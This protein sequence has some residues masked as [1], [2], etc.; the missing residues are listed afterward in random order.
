MWRRGPQR[1]AVSECD[2]RAILTVLA[3]LGRRGS[4]TLESVG[5]GALYNAVVADREPHKAVI[6]LVLSTTL[7]HLSKTILSVCAGVSLNVLEYAY[8]QNE[9]ITATIFECVHV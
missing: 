5:V 8:N 4:R 6:V 9:K 1:Q 3:W 7:H 2:G